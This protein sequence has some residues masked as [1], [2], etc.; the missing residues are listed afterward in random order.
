MRRYGP[1]FSQ[2][3]DSRDV[4]TE[5]IAF[6][7]VAANHRSSASATRAIHMYQLAKRLGRMRQYYD[8]RWKTCA[9]YPCYDALEKEAKSIGS[10]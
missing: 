7:D 6:A 8:R 4:I 10:R 1:S 2:S 5:Q 3:H 9:E